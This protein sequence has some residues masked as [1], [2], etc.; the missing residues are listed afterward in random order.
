[1]VNISTSYL[2]KG[3]LCQQVV[4]QVDILQPQ[5]SHVQITVML[6]QVTVKIKVEQK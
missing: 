2:L 4:Q 6:L 3:V 5:S 1:M